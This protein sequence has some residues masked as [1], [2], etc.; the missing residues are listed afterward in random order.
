MFEPLNFDAF[1]GKQLPAD[2]L[3]VL[4]TLDE[5]FPNSLVVSDLNEQGANFSVRGL[6]H[7][8][9]IK[10]MMA[11]KA[12]IFGP[13]VNAP[14]GSCVLGRSDFQI[15]SPLADQ[16]DRPHSAVSA[17]RPE[18]V[19]L[20]FGILVLLGPLGSLAF[21]GGSA[22]LV[23]RLSVNRRASAISARNVSVAGSRYSRPD[24]GKISP[25]SR[26]GSPTAGRTSDR[27]HRRSIGNSAQRPKAC[28]ATY[29]TSAAPRA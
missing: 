13:Q 5:L 11:Q 12:A 3:K 9:V 8:V 24:S 6:T 17:E 18:R 22:A 25:K 15:L 20:S 16:N 14:T 10:K 7:D 21:G 1:R 2:L 4:K 23:L 29:P 28:S 26:P 27:A 19:R